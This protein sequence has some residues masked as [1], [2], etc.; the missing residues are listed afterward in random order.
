MLTWSSGQADG[1]CSCA[2]NGVTCFQG[3]KLQFTL[4]SRY[5]IAV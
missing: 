2:A 3:L 1:G 4:E 5:S